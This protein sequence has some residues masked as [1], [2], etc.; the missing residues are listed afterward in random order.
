MRVNNEGSVPLVPDSTISGPASGNNMRNN[1]PVVGEV[2]S[3]KGSKGDPNIARIILGGFFGAIG[4][5]CIGAIKAVT[6]TPYRM[7]IAMS[8]GR[9]SILELVLGG[10][11]LIIQDAYIG[12][13]MGSGYSD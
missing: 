13:M 10:G 11:S 1:A 12:A 2:P 5:L 8:E 3:S 9:S 7:G 6:T 4:G